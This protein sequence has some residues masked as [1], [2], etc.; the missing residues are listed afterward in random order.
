MRR[1]KLTL[2]YEE[3]NEII[4]RSIT[5]QIPKDK[6]QEAFD[7]EGLLASKASELSLSIINSNIDVITWKDPEKSPMEVIMK[8]ASEGDSDRLVL[9]CPRLPDEQLNVMVLNM[10][11]IFSIL[12]LRRKEMQI[13]FL[14]SFWINRP[15]LYI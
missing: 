3:D 13:P 5:V 12:L 4:Q 15:G 1:F 9:T 8:T 6:E 10:Y 2:S 14:L 11:I 7:F